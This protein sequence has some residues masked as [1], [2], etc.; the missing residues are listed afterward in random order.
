M[1]FKTLMSMP[2]LLPFSIGFFSGS[3]YSQFFLNLAM[4]YMWAIYKYCQRHKPVNLEIQ[5]GT[6]MQIEV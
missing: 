1:R 3:S 2:L 4:I 6:A 5:S